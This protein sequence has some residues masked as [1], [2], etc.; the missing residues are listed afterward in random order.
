V[1]APPVS[2]TLEVDDDWPSFA[3]LQPPVEKTAIKPAIPLAEIQLCSLMT[4]SS[5]ILR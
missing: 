4:I 3:L 5:V 2:D 1:F